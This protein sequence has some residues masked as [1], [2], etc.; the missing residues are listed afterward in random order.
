[1]EE[2][3]YVVRDDSGRVRVSDP[4]L[5]LDAWRDE[6]RFSK[7]SIIRGHVAARSGDALTRFV[8]DVLSAANVE[9]AATG[10]SAAWQLTRFAGFRTA[11]FFVQAAPT[12]SVESDL[13][14]REEARGANLWLVVPND[15][16][17]FQGARER[18][19]VRCVHPVQVYLDLEEHPERAADAAE[20]IREEYLS[21]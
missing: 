6:Y 14:F 16:G 4:Q 18:G 12:A 10:L 21:W 19:G 17:V 1:L 15:A 5:L 13:G 9:H 11:T 7:H 8:A 3:H 2:E 20:R